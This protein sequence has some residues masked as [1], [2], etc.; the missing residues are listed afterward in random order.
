MI[1]VTRNRSVLDMCISQREGL[2]KPAR[3]LILVMFVWGQSYCLTNA[4]TLSLPSQ[5]LPC[6]PL[7]CSGTTRITWHFFFFWHLILFPVTVCLCQESVTNVERIE[8]IVVGQATILDKNNEAMTEGATF[9]EVHG[10]SE[11]IAQIQAPVTAPSCFSHE[12]K[13]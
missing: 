4:H 7:V 2:V 11:H 8:E 3:W 10:V 5:S 1:L 9:A 13:S 6:C 12:A